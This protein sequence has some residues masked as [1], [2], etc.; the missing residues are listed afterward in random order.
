MAKVGETG[1]ESMDRPESLDPFASYFKTVK[2][3]DPE[4]QYSGVLSMF[5]I[6]FIGFILAPVFS[7]G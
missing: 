6:T 4:R 5:P 3:K 1:E 7:K 2:N